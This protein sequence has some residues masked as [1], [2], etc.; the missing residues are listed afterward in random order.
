MHF[1]SRNLKW[2]LL[3]SVKKW[4]LLVPSL[5]CA[6]KN[7]WRLRQWLDMSLIVNARKARHGDLQI[8]AKIRQFGGKVGQRTISCNF[9]VMGCVEKAKDLTQGKRQWSI[10][11]LGCLFDTVLDHKQIRNSFFFSVHWNSFLGKSDLV[12]R[13]WLNDFGEGCVQRMIWK[14]V[15]EGDWLVKLCWV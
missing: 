4:L 8:W 5:T 12:F 13:V 6:N 15:S 10:F 9:E 3:I 2:A 11:H 7:S 14:G 1:W